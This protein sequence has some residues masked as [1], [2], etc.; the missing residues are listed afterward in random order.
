MPDGD[1]RVCFVGDSFVAGLGDSSGLGWVGRVTVAGLARGLPLTAY[2]LGVRRDT[3]VLV[4]ERIGREVR[5]RLEPASD[6]RV[7]VS[8]GVNDTVLEEGAAR[9]ASADTVAALERSLLAV[10]PARMLLVGP[11]AVDDDAHNERLDALNGVLR[12]KSSRLGL[13]FVDS[14][15]G[16]ATDATWRQQVRAGDGY[17]PDAAGYRR[18]AELVGGPV[19]DWLSREVPGATSPR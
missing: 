12:T 4:S 3:S 18:L 6:P 11:P 16:T 7:V 5:P 19:L 2:N 17:H 10:A 14:F 9:V 1:V 8:F 13:A 15:S